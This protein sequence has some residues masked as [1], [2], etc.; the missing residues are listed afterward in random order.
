[1][2][3]GVWGSDLFVRLDPQEEIHTLL[4][5][6]FSTQGARS[7]AVTS[8][9]G[10][11]Q[12]VDIGYL[13]EHGVYQRKVLTGAVELLSL[14]GN[15]AEMDG[16][17]FT[18]LHVVVSD[19]EHRVHGGHLFSAVIAVTAEIHIRIFDDSSNGGMVMNRCHIDGSQFKPLRFGVDS[20]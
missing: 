11:V 19:D 14:Q 3:L 13:D 5:E 1:M 8:G 6:V 7:G 2:E 18:H 4:K 20:E 15:V 9:I 10:R 12:N 17:L 16:R